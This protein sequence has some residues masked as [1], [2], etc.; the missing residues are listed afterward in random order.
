MR[1]TGPAVWDASRRE[2]NLP[3]GG[4]SRGA[5]CSKPSA[6]S[7][8]YLICDRRISRWLIDSNVTPRSSAAERRSGMVASEASADALSS[9]TDPVRA[10]LYLVTP[11]RRAVPPCW[12]YGAFVVAWFELDLQRPAKSEM[13]T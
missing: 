2:P 5:E 13:T 1:L 11:K 8:R 9:K 6:I 3:H 4:P 12:R 10:H 7:R